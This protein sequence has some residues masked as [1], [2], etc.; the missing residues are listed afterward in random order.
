M[1]TYIMLFIHLAPE[2]YLL[3]NSFYFSFFIFI[4]V[5]RFTKYKIWSKPKVIKNQNIIRGISLYTCVPTD[6]DHHTR[7]MKFYCPGLL[8]Y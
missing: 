1:I 7:N 4:F 3:A 5:K 8:A 6:N 2:N